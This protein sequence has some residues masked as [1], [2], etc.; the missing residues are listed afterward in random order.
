MKRGVNILVKGQ[1]LKIKWNT[2]NKKH[3]VDQGCI[4]TK[5]GD[6]FTIDIDNIIPMGNINIKVECDYCHK[7]FERKY[8]NYLTSNKNCSKDACK[9]CGATKAYEIH[10]EKRKNETFDK[11]EK[12]LKEKDYVLLT[13]RNDFTTVRMSIDYICKEH[14]KQTAILDNLL[15]GHGCLS[16]KYIN[17]KQ[18]LRNNP[19]DIEKC[20][21]SINNNTLLNKEDYVGVYEKNLKILCGICRKNIFTT[22]FDAYKWKNNNTCVECSNRCSKN[23][24]KIHQ[25]L[26]RLNL[27]Y[28]AE[29]TFPDCK[30][31]RRLI[32][33]FYIPKYNLLIEYDGEGH[34]LEKF[35]KNRFK[36]TK[37]ALLNAQ[38]RDEIKNNYCKK[39]NIPLLRI[40]YWEKDNL[41]EIIINKINEL[42]NNLDRR[43]SLVS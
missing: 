13:D 17:Q 33:D 32:F 3:Y 6:E 35:Y 29:K 37:L 39:N 40:P 5:M 18:Q 36:D 12:I 28:E 30:S 26:M 22:S 41:E 9:S 11:L 34:Y 1:K 31:V 27:N 38:K 14:G 43:Y 7:I 20:I 21:N 25:L 15:C 10:F 19:D 23:E 2:K 42:E 8:Y 24:L 16:C 4:Y